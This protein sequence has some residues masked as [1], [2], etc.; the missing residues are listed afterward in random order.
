MLT[1][2]ISSIFGVLAPPGAPHRLR[3]GFAAPG[4]SGLPPFLLVFGVPALGR[5]VLPLTELC[6]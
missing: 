2:L 5:M 6:E 1:P 4:L 3:S